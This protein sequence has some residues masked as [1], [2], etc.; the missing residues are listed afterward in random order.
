MIYPRRLIYGVANGREITPGYITSG[1]TEGKTFK[2]IKPAVD[3]KRA[4]LQ[5]VEG[6]ETKKCD[7]KLVKLIHSHVL[8]IVIKRNLH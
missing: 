5:S 2:R 7:T 6:H 3:D 4:R 8:L 1:T